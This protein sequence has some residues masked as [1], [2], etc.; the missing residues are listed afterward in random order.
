MREVVEPSLD[1]CGTPDD[2]SSRDGCSN[3]CMGSEIGVEPRH[4]LTDQRL[5]IQK[6]G[7]SYQQ[8][9]LI[10]S[11]VIQLVHN[12]FLRFGVLKGFKEQN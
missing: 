9:V 2:S 4:W 8:C 3:E 1:P 6:D 11:C 5:Q 10:E 12:I 7:R